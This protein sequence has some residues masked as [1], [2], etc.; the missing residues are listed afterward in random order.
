MPSGLAEDADSSNI[1]CMCYKK[2]AAGTRSVSRTRV[3]PGPCPRCMPLGLGRCHDCALGSDVHLPLGNSPA[4]H[5][6]TMPGPYPVAAGVHSLQQEDNPWYETC[7]VRVPVLARAQL[8]Q[9]L[10]RA[11][12]DTCMIAKF[13]YMERN[14]NPSL[15]PLRS[16]CFSYLLPL[17]S[18]LRRG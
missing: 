7:S 18:L 12:C 9:T 10:R 11:F 2:S 15:T 6:W 4:V 3:K 17:W 8:F 1:P 5:A 13:T 14:L 16:S